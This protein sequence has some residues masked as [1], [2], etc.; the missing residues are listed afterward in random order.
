MDLFNIKPITLL[1]GSHEDTGKTGQ[2]CFM[3]VIAYLN[4]EE[5]IT[6]QSE[7]V[8]PLIRSVAIWMNDH[9]YDNDRQ[10]MLPFVL[11]AMGTAYDSDEVKQRR[12]R[13]I[14]SFWRR[15]RRAIEQAL[16]GI[17]VPTGRWF[18]VG[19]ERVAY[20]FSCLDRFTFIA[21]EDA[22][23]TFDAA[24]SVDNLYIDLLPD[25]YHGWI[26]SLFDLMDSLLPPADAP[27]Q[28]VIE[29]AAK[30]VEVAYGS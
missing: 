28:L 8:D 1:Q 11:R 26:S 23:F 16:Y 27:T 4:G 25:L 9:L 21:I 6:D 19:S 24:T 13:R 18:S 29:R 22:V 14:V 15:T 3:N 17:P 5:T 12:A 7:C 10:A 20:H 2:G 30:L